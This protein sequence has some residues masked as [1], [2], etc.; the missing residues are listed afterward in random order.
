MEIGLKGLRQLAWL[1]E[2]QLYRGP[3][4]LTDANVNST[5]IYLVCFARIA[6]INSSSKKL[7]QQTSVR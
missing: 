5:T 1:G 3:P 7:V 6:Q 4:P 2:T